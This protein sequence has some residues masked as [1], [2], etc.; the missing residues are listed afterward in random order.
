MG[1]DLLRKQL[2]G[3]RAR[4]KDDMPCTTEWLALD[5]MERASALWLGWSS[6]EWDQHRYPA[7]YSLE[8]TELSHDEKEAAKTLGC[9]PGPLGV[10][11]VGEEGAGVPSGSSALSPSTTRAF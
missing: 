4:R 3:R 5:Q 2:V 1:W 9:A 6:S 11:G 10:D 8:W 7:I